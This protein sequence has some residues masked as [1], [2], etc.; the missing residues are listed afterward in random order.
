MGKSKNC[1]VCRKG[2]ISRKWS[3]LIP[4]QH[5]C[6]FSCY[7]KGERYYFLVF[8]TIFSFGSFI[9]F[10]GM[11]YDL[12]INHLEAITPYLNIIIPIFALTII[13]FG[14]TLVGFKVEIKKFEDM[15]TKS[16]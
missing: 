15:L 3:P 14:I 7:A 11:I 12:A 1:S 9:I 4:I 6:S 2:N 13:H 10:L 16:F 8:A 5:Y